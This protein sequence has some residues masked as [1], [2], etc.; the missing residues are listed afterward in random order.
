[1]LPTHRASQMPHVF[2]MFSML[3][4]SEVARQRIADFINSGELDELPAILVTDVV[5]YFCPGR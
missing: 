2:S 4:E 1:M 5:G 3:P